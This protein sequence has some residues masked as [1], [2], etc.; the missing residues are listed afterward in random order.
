MKDSAETT[1][2][3]QAGQHRKTERAEDQ[4]GTTAV[5]QSPHLVAHA[6]VPG[7]VPGDGAAYPKQIGATKG[8]PASLA[9]SATDMQQTFTALDSG[10]TSGTEIGHWTHTG[11]TSA[12]AGFD[13]PALGWIGVRAE[14]GPSGV[15]ASVLPGSADAVQSMHSYL[16]ELNAY[17]AEHR[18][19]VETVAVAAPASEWTGFAQGHQGGQQSGQQGRGEAERN[20]AADG[21]SQAATSGA[22]SATQVTAK[23]DLRGTAATLMYGAS[24]GRGSLSVIA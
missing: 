20:D 18:V 12:E 13:D 19:P 10:G 14:L 2:A 23:T 6:I 21:R 3:Q 5:L 15:H 16:P 4:S 24:R 11:K 1:A 17:L 8:E 9:P 22:A 7:I